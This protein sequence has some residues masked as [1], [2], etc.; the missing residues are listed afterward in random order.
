[1]QTWYSRRH[2][3]SL[4]FL[5]PYLAPGK[6]MVISE[7]DMGYDDG[8]PARAEAVVFALREIVGPNP[9]V[10]YVSHWWN[11]DDQEGS[12][13]WEKHQTRKGGALRPV[14]AAVQAFREG[15]AAP[16]PVPPPPDPA[17]P[18][19]AGTID[20][21]AWCTLRRAIVPPGNK[22]WRIVRAYWRDSD[23]SGGT[24]HIYALQP[25]NPAVSMKVRWENTT[26]T[27][28]LDKPLNEPAGNYAMFGAEYMAWLE[29]GGASLSD[30][31]SGMKLPQNQHVSYYIEW[32][33]AENEA[34]PPPPSIPAA[35]KTLLLAEAERRQ[36]LQF[37][38]TAALQK[39]IFAGDLDQF[40]P[41]SPEFYVTYENR[42]YVGQR[43]ENGRGVV[44]VYF[45]PSGVWTPVQFVERGGA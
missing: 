40:T 37:N 21:P 36:V 18:P 20:L 10:A 19:P 28:P 29:G 42:V 27:V 26:D 41:N 32:E 15:A 44:R 25:H 3:R 8:Q 35:L 38:P 5:R 2:E 17:P 30:S 33:L 6:K 39:V 14:V 45:A 1:L 11:G 9:D 16:D 31:V 22:Y 4:M 7:W 13:T 23:T 43:A 34:P 24:H 12:A